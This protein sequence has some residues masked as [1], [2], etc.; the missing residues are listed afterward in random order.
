MSEHPGAAG[1]TTPYRE[2]VVREVIINGRR[3]PVVTRYVPWTPL[4]AHR[5][6]RRFGAGWVDAL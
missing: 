4:D 5:A 6:W 3:W 1:V 2:M